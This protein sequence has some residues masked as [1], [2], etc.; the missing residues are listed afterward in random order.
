[1]DI[2]KYTNRISYT[3]LIKSANGM[4]DKLEKKEEAEGMIVVD[5][6]KFAHESSLH[7]SRIVLHS[8]IDIHCLVLVYILMLIDILNTIRV[9]RIF[10]AA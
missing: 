1:M 6:N 3:T 4:A 2:N 9:T 10:Y 5:L 7:E 8:E